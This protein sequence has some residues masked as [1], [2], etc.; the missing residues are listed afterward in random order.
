M[1]F[2]GGGGG[3]GA[4]LKKIRITRGTSGAVIKFLSSYFVEVITSSISSCT[5]VKHNTNQGLHL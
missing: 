4:H 1:F 5:K 3:G 2:F